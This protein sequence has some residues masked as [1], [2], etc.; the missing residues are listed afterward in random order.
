MSASNSDAGADAGPARSDAGFTL[1]ETLVALAVFA[2]AFGGIYRAFDGGWR[3]LRRAQLDVEAVE[4]AK[5]S[6]AAVGVETPLTEGRQTG[7]TADGVSWQ[8]DIRRRTTGDRLEFRPTAPWP[9]AFDVR[10]SARRPSPAGDGGQT[11]E[12]S[13]IKLGDQPQ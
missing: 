4:V 9:A 5:S 12:L 6:L 8:I 10:V 2:L 13:T 3:A 7:R 11:V 1:V